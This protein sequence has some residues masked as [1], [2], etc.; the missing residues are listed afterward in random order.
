MDGSDATPA[1]AVDNRDMMK[2]EIASLLEEITTIG[3]ADELEVLRVHLRAMK[4]QPP[5]ANRA[6]LRPATTESDISESDPSSH[7]TDTSDASNQS[8]FTGNL[9]ELSEKQRAVLGE[10]LG[11]RDGTAVSSAV[12]EPD[13]SQDGERPH[14]EE[15]FRNDIRL[16]I[17]KMCDLHRQMLEQTAMR[18]APSEIRDEYYA[19]LANAAVQN[20]NTLAKKRELEARIA[21]FELVKVEQELRRLE[22]ETAERHAGN[23][24]SGSVEDATVSPQ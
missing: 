10:L 23:D 15:G 19:A 14:R 21:E 5:E 13:D 4:S 18:S 7:Q 17:E 6:T 16:G 8:E 24:G 2:A 9:D 3:S 12:A 11:C 22:Q 20:A 1:A